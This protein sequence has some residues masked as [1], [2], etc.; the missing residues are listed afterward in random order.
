MPGSIAIPG[1]WRDG[2]RTASFI[3]NRFLFSL[4]AILYQLATGKPAF[5]G[6]TSIATARAIADQSHP[7]LKKQNPDLPAWLV[8]LID[9]LLAKAPED[10]P[11]DAKEVWERISTKSDQT[12]KKSHSRRRILAMAAGFAVVA[13]AWLIF[14]P[15]HPTSAWDRAKFGNARTSEG[16]ATLPEAIAAAAPG[17]AIEIRVNGVAHDKSLPT[18]DKPLILRAAPGFEPSLTSADRSTPLV[19]NTAPLVLEGLRI[20]QLSAS[21]ESPPVVLAE[22]AL[23][24][25][26][27]SFSREARPVPGRVDLLPGIIVVAGADR[28]DLLNCALVSAASLGLIIESGDSDIKLTNLIVATPTGIYF[29][30]PRSQLVRLQITQSS[31]HGKGLA[32][33]ERREN[34]QLAPVDFTMERSAIETTVGMFG[35]PARTLEIGEVAGEFSRIE[36]SL[37]ARHPLPSPLSKRQ[38]RAPQ[39]AG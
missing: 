28:L 2:I 16:Y 31:F 18:I 9:D 10:R 25:T 33:W 1:W 23:Y 19:H 34:R 14:R 35:T 21:L 37:F 12:P 24:A 39:F 17:D 7:L 3:E 13:A 8:S 6:D 22:A 30:H 32:A 11:K 4:G 26:N 29:R 36:E 5:S 38:W 15:A 20:R 27:C